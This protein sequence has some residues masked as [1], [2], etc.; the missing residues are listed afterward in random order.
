MARIDEVLT[1]EKTWSQYGLDVLGHAGLGAAYALPVAALGAWR[2]W[3]LA[4]VAV[5]ALA[6]ALGGGA[7]REWIQ[8]RSTGKLHL[9]DRALDTA[10]HALGVP[11]AMGLAAFLP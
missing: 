9:L 1:G 10:H 4:I 3:Q 7:L 2:D 5:A 6:F 8:A 11:I